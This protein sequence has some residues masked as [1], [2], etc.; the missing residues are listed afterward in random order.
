M[1]RGL[2]GQG[3]PGHGQ[4]LAGADARR[5]GADSR[6]EPDRAAG[7]LG[8]DRLGT[9]ARVWAAVAAVYRSAGPGTCGGQKMRNHD[10]LTQKLLEYVDHSFA[11]FF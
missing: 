7:R 6:V 3:H 11:R 10:K 1:G 2:Q 4:L 9:A 5:S 8:V